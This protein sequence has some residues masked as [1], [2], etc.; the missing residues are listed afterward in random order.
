MADM[1]SIMELAN[2]HNLVVIEDACQA[3][4]AEYKGRKAG[5]IGNA[6]CFSFYPSKNLGGCGDGGMISVK[7]EEDKTLCVS[8]RAH[9]ENPKY[10]HR[11]VGY[12]SRLDSMQAAI[13]LV[14]LPHLQDWS[15]KRRK[16]A[17]RYD[18]ALSGLSTLTTPAVREFSTYHIYIQ[19]T[20]RSPKREEILGGLKAAGIDYC[21]YYPVPFHAQD[22]F[23]QLGYK[24][25]E[26]PVSSKAAREVFSIPIYPELTHDEQSEVIDTLKRLT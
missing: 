11:L 4:G 12:N 25:E 9:G 6:G 22:C 26:F 2:T 17:H 3:H 19:Y 10:Y 18:E 16:H 5:S 15:D 7:T 24:P 8:L 13:L 20:L 14:Q 21:I 23:K 1:D